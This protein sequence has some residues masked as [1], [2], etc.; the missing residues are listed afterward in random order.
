MM[1][2]LSLPETARLVKFIYID[3][4]LFLRYNGIIH[5]RVGADGQLK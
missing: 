4:L 2:H 5:R 3:T 1:L